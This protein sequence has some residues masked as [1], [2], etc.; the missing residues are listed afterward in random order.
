M[1][2]M[3]ETLDFTELRREMVDLQLRARGIR[4]ERVLAAM[5]RVPR[6]AFVDAAHRCSAYADCALP[7]GEGQTISQPYTVAFMAEA[8][9]IAPTDRVLEIGT[10]SGY[11]AAVLSHLA[12]E[13]YTVERL[14]DLAAQAGRRLAERG[15]ADVHVLTRDGTSGLPEH[16]PYDA[17]VVTAGAVS[18]PEP[19][20]AQ[21]APRG[22]IVIPIGE[23]HLGQTM[24]RFT[25]VDGR[26]EAEALG[27]FAFVPLIGAYTEETPPRS[28]YDDFAAR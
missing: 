13:V 10:G 2:S 19:L 16:A 20:V 14:P 7:I 5:N 24:Y 27:E 8:A 17:I 12:A 9:Q 22:R 25:K 21:L 6:E 18:L 11:G 26:L 15:Y 3:F 28:V 1:M 4:D 23:F